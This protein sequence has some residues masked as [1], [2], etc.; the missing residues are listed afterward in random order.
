MDAKMKRI[1]IIGGGQL[2]MMLAQAAHQLG[3]GIAILAESID[4]PVYSMLDLE[5]DRFVIGELSNYQ[6]LLEL[7]SCSDILSCA[8]KSCVTATASASPATCHAA[9]P[10]RLPLS[11]SR[12][13]LIRAIFV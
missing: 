4:C 1:G 5:K 2:A 13:A 7:A 12:N 3:F 11:Q 8:R 10:N 6:K 9:S